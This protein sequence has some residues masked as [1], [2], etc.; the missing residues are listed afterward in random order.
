MLS[1]FPEKAGDCVL[2]LFVTELS[3][4]ATALLAVSPEYGPFS[5]LAPLRDELWVTTADRPRALP[6][7]PGVWKRRVEAT[8]EAT[9]G[10]PLLG[11]SKA[12]V[13]PDRTA[14]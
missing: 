7:V 10:A 9:V 3:L 6:P 11:S 5:T 8:V 1:W 12:V 2:L 4:G 14:W 13:A